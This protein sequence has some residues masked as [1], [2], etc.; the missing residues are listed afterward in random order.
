MNVV[1]QRPV[2]MAQQNSVDVNAISVTG[3][4]ASAG[5]S[6][7]VT[8]G[9]NAGGTHG[10]TATISGADAAYFSIVDASGN[11]ILK[12]NIA[13]PGGALFVK[14]APDATVRTTKTAILTLSASSNPAY[15][16]V[17]IHINLSGNVTVTGLNSTQYQRVLTLKNNPVIDQL[18]V[19]APFT[20]T[21]EWTIY[22]NAGARVFNLIASSQFT[23][24]V[25][26][27]NAG[28]YMIKAVNKAT[29]ENGIIK[30]IKK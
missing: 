26:N 2:L 25:S 18:Q 12:N 7:A 10:I 13:L 30:F 24:N 22:N 27:L 8:V 4:I 14:F 17:P 28:I 5:I 1:G 6:T 19:S 29:G 20:G 3:S 11:P 16:A 15:G 21:V 23:T 9:C